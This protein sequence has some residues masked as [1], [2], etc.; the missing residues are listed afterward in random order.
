MLKM[1]EQV[2]WTPMHLSPLTNGI[3][4]REECQTI[5]QERV[6]RDRIR[7]A[8]FLN[9]PEI[10]PYNTLVA[11]ITERVLWQKVFDWFRAQR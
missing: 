9:L 3:P 2:L 8:H 6:E 7:L 10:T 11:H 1:S 4:L 5:E